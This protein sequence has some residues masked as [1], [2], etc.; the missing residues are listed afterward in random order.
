MKT[1]NQPMIE[2]LDL[3]ATAYSPAGGTVIDG[4]YVSRNGKYDIPTYGP[5]GQEQPE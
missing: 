2:E 4:S 5:S 3:N 1:W